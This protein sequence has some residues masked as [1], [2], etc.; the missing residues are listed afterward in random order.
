[1]APR[2]RPSAGSQLLDIEERFRLMVE[3]VK[4]YAIF[5]LDVEGRVISWNAG[6]ERLKGYGPEEILGQHFSRFYPSEDVRAGKPERELESAIATGRVE[7]EGWRVRKDGSRFWAD[8]VITAVRNE[9]GELLGFAKVTRDLTE[10]RRV[11]EALRAANAEL[12]RFTYSVSHDLRAPLRAI[13]G[14]ARALDEDRG[15][16]LDAEARRLLAVIRDNA[17]RMGHLIDALLNFSRLGRQPLGRARVNMSE[18]ARGV[19]EELRRA[20]GQDVEVALQPLPAATGDA[21]LLRQVFANLIGNALKFS[22]GR[23]RPRV[24][25]GARQEGGEAV[26]YVRDNGAGFDMRY[27]D[28]LFGVFQ[29]LHH[30]DEFEGTGVGLALAHRIVERHGGRVWAEGKVGEGATFYFTLPPT[31]PADR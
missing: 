9:R 4:D 8:V 20:A 10:R 28:K 12:E 6:A 26:Y 1:M 15:P 3:S 25:I 17:K 2:K 19:V 5:M 29:R 11:E 24:E 27:A 14:Y 31:L 18:L 16:T 13:D 7:D 30:V 22:R 21:T 23:P